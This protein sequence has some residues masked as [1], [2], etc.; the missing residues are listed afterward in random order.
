MRIGLSLHTYCPEGR[1]IVPKF[2]ETP[3]TAVVTVVAAVALVSCSDNGQTDLEATVQET[4]EVT[5]SETITETETET[6]VE[7][8]T[9][10]EAVTETSAQVDDK[11]VP[12]SPGNTCETP[13][14]PMTCEKTHMDSAGAFDLVPVDVRAGDHGT[15]DRVV[16]EF[17]GE[18]SPGWTTQY[19]DTP[20]HQASGL[21]L[22]VSGTRNLEVMIHGTPMAM[23]WPQWLMDGGHLG[24]AAGGVQNVYSASAFEGDSQWVIELDEK[25][26]YFVYTMEN[27]NR[28]V[29]EFA[30]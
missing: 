21:P 7:T 23:P 18:G 22:D 25:R 11:Q 30:K 14:H 2:L 26:P 3:A 17:E 1:T 16:F 19:V 10:T 13:A 27:P 29:I 6:H 12:A 20:L 15:F 8:E 24:V 28:L 9:T 5:S 4:Q